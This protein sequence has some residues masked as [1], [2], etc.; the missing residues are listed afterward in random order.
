MHAYLQV[1]V[2]FEALRAQFPDVSEVPHGQQSK[3]YELLLR[4]VPFER[5]MQEPQRLIREDEDDPDKRARAEVPPEPG[6]VVP[7]QGDTDTDSDVLMFEELAEEFWQDVPDDI[8][9]RDLPEGSIEGDAGETAEE[10]ATALEAAAAEAAVEEEA[11]GMP[12]AASASD[13]PSGLVPPFLDRPGKWGC[14]PH[15]NQAAKE[16]LQVWSI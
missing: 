9:V 14:F 6:D 16:R 13:E 15:F 4:G 2:D 5:H 3:V 11:A 8:A 7:S 12:S 1:L 10:V